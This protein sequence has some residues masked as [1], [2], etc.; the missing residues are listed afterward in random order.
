MRLDR[1]AYRR[2]SAVGFNEADLLG[3]DASIFAGVLH[4]SRLR[5][6]AGQRDAVG[7]SIL[8]DRRPQNHPLNRIAIRDR[9]AKVA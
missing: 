4:Q 7:V 8:I 6:R 9:A 1:I 2:P 5:L 3:R